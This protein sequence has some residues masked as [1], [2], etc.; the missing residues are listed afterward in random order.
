MIFGI[1][2]D[3]IGFRYTYMIVLILN[4]ITS[5]TLKLSVE[6]KIS[7]AFSF[8]FIGMC[9]GAHFSIFPVKTIQI[10]GLN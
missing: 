2:L 7:Y 5:L 3:K 8:L 9:E 10:F 1:I 4:I 6:N